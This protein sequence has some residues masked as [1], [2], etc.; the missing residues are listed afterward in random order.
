MKLMSHCYYWYSIVGG[1]INSCSRNLTRRQSMDCTT[2]LD[3]EKCCADTSKTGSSCSLHATA[4]LPSRHVASRQSTCSF[5]PVSDHRSTRKTNTQALLVQQRRAS[6]VPRTA[7]KLEALVHKSHQQQ[8]QHG[9]VRVRAAS[10][11]G[12]TASGLGR[13]RGGRRRGGAAVR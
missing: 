4:F 12:A 7:P 11:T 6:P 1:S 5:Q 13:P 3:F 2:R 10:I 8:H 9:V